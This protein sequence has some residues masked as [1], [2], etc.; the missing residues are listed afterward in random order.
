VDGTLIE[1]W[2][3]HKS[4]QP[5]AKERPNSRKKRRDR[6]RRDGGPRNPTVDFRG[7]RRINETHQST[8]D[9]EARLARSKGQESRLSYQ[10]HVLTENRHG[11]VVDARLTPADGYAERAAA[12]EMLGELAEG[13]RVTL[14]ADRGYDTQDFWRGAGPWVTGVNYFCRLTTTI[15][16]A[17]GVSPLSSSLL[18]EVTGGDR[19]FFARR[20]EAAGF[21]PF[22][23][24]P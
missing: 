8:T 3:S 16:A 15:P 13:P 10:G 5:K 12:L 17:V 11:L 9:P 19:S 1:A 14:G 2:A 7:E 21:S 20:R 6:N 18:Q 22:A 24:W 23:A 4:F